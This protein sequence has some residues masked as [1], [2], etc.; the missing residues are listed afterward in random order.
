[1]EARQETVPTEEAMNFVQLA[2]QKI[3]VDDE[4]QCASQHGKK[5][6]PL[7]HLVRTGKRSPY[8]V[9]C[10]KSLSPEERKKLKGG[11]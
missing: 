6:P 5:D 10:P 8:L 1:M 7:F 11:K 3:L 2:G 9:R 4:A